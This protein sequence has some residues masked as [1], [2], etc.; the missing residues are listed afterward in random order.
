M[1]GQT[2]TTMKTKIEIDFG[3]I[4]TFNF[5]KAMLLMFKELKE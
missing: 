2:Y 4:N 3:E 5:R 1:N